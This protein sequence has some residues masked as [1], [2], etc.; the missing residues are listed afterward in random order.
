M[1]RWSRRPAALTE[2]RARR[3]A[4]GPYPDVGI[5]R[6]RLRGR[7]ARIARAAGFYCILI[8]GA[9]VARPTVGTAGGP[10]RPRPQATDAGTRRV[11]A[12]CVMPPRRFHHTLAAAAL[13]LSDGRQDERIA[14]RTPRPCTRR[15]LPSDLLAWVGRHGGSLA[16]PFLCRRVEISRYSMLL[17]C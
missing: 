17:V 15:P 10:H 12:D 6:P 5:G 1:S 4:V 13:T 9:L 16:A 11:P 3:W 14:G 2:R 8:R 7:G